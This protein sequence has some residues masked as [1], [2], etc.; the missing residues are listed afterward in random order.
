MLILPNDG[1]NYGSDS[2]DAKPIVADYDGNQI[3]DSVKA[4]E[5]TLVD[6]DSKTDHNRESDKEEDDDDEDNDSRYDLYDR[7]PFPEPDFKQED[8][9]Y[10]DLTRSWIMLSIRF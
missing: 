3:L 4:E 9:E 5:Q 1:F 8:I 2:S 10:I 6:N 7:R